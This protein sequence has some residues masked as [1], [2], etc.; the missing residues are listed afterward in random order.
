[1]RHARRLGAF[2]GVV[3]ALAGGAWGEYDAEACGGCFTAPLPPNPPPDE[4]DSV[5]TDERMIFSVSTTQTTLYD[6]INFSGNPASF[7]WVLPIK[8][9][10]TVGL[11]ADI[12]FASLDSL[13]GTQVIAPP[14]NCPPPPSCGGGGG[15]GGCSSSVSISGSSGS[16]FAE[17]ISADGGI[18]APPVTVTAQVQVG[19]YETVQLKSTD[20][21]A[22]D[23]WLSSHGYEVAA[24]EAPVVA[25]YVAEGFDFLAMKLV[26]GQGVN[27]MRP[28]RV[29]TVG[30]GVT[31]PLRMVSVGTGATT[32]VT[33]WVIGDARWEP[34]NFPTFTIA[35]SELDWDW[36]TES[37][38]YETVRL[39]HEAA[40]KGGG[41]EIESSLEI[42][43]AIITS[44]VQTANASPDGDAAPGSSDYLA[45]G[46]ADAGQ[47]PVPA[48]DGGTDAGVSD[49]SSGVA[50]QSADEVE[51]AD[52]STLF[53]G[54]T[55]PN[56]RVT[57]MR[58]D[59]VHSALS[60]DL[61]IQAS[62]DQ[63]ELTNLHYPTRQVG[64]PLCPIYDANCNAIGEAPR[65]ATTQSSSGGCSTTAQGSPIGTQLI[66]VGCA[67]FLGL[68][69]LRSRRKA[70]RRARR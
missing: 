70:R 6:E 51:Q 25:A 63:S 61:V 53:A 39:Q 44:T 40:L 65:S 14:L 54:M 18:A 45:I 21:G 68:G 69:S 58:S 31:L 52:L 59:L 13:T 42:N 17:D 37:S 36:A 3:A 35:D 43:E 10:A 66:A 47:G 50:Y 67:A 56:V 29:T 48:V 22:L 60:A 28:V 8:G 27:A 19:P 12:L 41:W 23:S 5:I 9:T 32:G 11:S 38:N 1:M 20:S 62:T 7:A 55:G 34:S 30:A 4:V 15:G 49:A 46:D 16:G 24:S 33:L 57:R 64:E 2:L 26:P